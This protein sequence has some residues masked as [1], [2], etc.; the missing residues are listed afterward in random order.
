MKTLLLTAL[1]AILPVSFA[2]SNDERPGN[3]DRSVLEIQP[4]STITAAKDIYMLARTSNVALQG[5]RGSLPFQQCY[6]QAYQGAQV[7]RVIRTGR[8]FKIYR[9]QLTDN[10]L[11]LKLDDGRKDHIIAQLGCTLD[12]RYRGTLPLIGD[13][14]RAIEATFT[15]E[16]V[17]S[18]VEEVS[19]PAE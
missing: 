2:L 15:A 14:T 18:P 10:Y 17:D 6:L 12:G 13:L 8:V 9:V 4:G 19:F 5:S 16:F 3:E 11:I 1:M 7:D